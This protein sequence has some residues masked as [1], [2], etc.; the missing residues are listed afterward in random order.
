MS[1]QYNKVEKRSRR[2]AYLKRAKSRVKAAM[3][4]SKKK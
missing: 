3:T 2:S 4:S 1:R